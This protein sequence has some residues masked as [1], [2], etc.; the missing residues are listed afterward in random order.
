MGLGLAGPKSH[1]V[2]E[3]HRDELL[4]VVDHLVRVRVRVRVGV[5]V[6]VRVRV[7]TLSLTL[8]CAKARGMMPRSSGGSLMPS[9]VNVFPVPG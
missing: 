8:T 1:H 5:R 2:G 9:I 4:R 3:A 7:L 6:A